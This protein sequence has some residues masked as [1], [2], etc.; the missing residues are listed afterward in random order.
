MKSGLPGAGQ[1]SHHLTTSG[2]HL[3]LELM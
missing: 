3:W 1:L 2:H